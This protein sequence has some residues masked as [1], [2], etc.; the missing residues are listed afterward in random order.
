MADRKDPAGRSDAA[1][2][3][4]GEHRGTDR[5]P[6]VIQPM[7]RATA[8]RASI[9][10]LL[11]LGLVASNIRAGDTEP[12]SKSWAVCAAS[13][14]IAVGT[15][16][17]RADELRAASKQGRYLDATVDVS[18]TLKGERSETI[19]V[20][21]FSE[22]RP[23]APN[24]NTLLALNGRPVMVFLT[25]IPD[26]D[27]AGRATNYFARYTADALRVSSPAEVTNIRMEVA[28]QANV[29]RTWGPHPEWPHEAEVK[30]LIE[31]M[32]RR[33]TAAQAF[34]DLEKLG[35]SGVPAIVDLMDDRRPL[36]TSFMS[37]EN[38][39][40]RS[41]RVEQ[42][43]RPQARRRCIGSDPRSDHRTE[44]R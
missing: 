15:L 25:A 30:G 6:A 21:F 38:K 28:R 22:N 43:L 27:T 7:G 20:R 19:V 34:K 8:A 29:L 2:G 32:L 44:F 5:I 12:I 35:S 9:T 26:P 17:V 24:S 31:K 36:G 41:I 23:Y 1:K 11:A 10:A 16:H 14:T 42:N 18:E 4:L 39:S 3:R 40:P 37:L 33:E 13:T